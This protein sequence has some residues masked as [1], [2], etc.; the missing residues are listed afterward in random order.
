MEQRSARVNLIVGLFAIAVLAGGGYVV[1]F[2]LG[3][4]APISHSYRVRD[5]F[6]DVGGLRHG[7]PVT[8]M[9]AHIGHVDRMYI[10]GAEPPKFPQTSWEVV[11]ALR[12]E[13]WVKE[14][15]REDSSFSIVSENP[16]IS[17]KYVNVT[18][19]TKAAP[20]LG[21]DSVVG[22]TV[23]AGFDSRTFTKLDQTLTNAVEATNILRDA[24]REENQNMIRTALDDIAK[25]A[26]NLSEVTERMKAGMD[27]WSQ[28]IENMKFWKGW[29]GE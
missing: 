29:F 16:I 5:R 17:T 27:S 23:G 14:Q 21:P 24:L 9:G 22:G 25:A 18:F 11:L 26:K 6:E 15:V 13:P 19:G 20:E 12:D 2:M 1:W 3:K 28:T 8:L 7:A 10:V 4:E